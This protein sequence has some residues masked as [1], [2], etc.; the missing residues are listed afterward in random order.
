MAVGAKDIHT[1]YRT[2]W[3]VLVA[4]TLLSLGVVWKSRHDKN[5]LQMMPCPYLKD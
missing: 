2:G 4:S 1:M 5:I 3:A